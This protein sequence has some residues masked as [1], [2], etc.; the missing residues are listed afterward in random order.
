MKHVH[1]II[2][3][4]PLA[5]SL[6]AAQ[7]SIQEATDTLHTY[8]WAN[9]KELEGNYAQAALWYDKLM[10]SQPPYHVHKGH[11]TFL[12]ATGQVGKI[13][14]LMPSLETLFA[15]DVEVQLIFAQALQ[16]VGKTA[17]AENRFLQLSNKFKHDQSVAFQAASIY[18]RRHELENALAT[19]DNVL[20]GS[21]KKQ[22]NFIFH[23]LKAQIYMQANQ[24]NKAL[25]SIKE[26]LAL[27]PRFDKGI[28]LQALLEE[29][30]GRLTQAM[31]GF[32]TYLEI[33]GSQDATIKQHL[34]Q[35][36][37]KQKIAQEHINSAIMNKT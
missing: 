22:N 27:H 30:A 35:L 28:L 8:L 19:I 21:P 10:A 25:Q 15:D 34:L 14:S 9:Y 5:A 37:F 26:S 4:L 1:Y 17:D 36:A 24:T 3:L 13:L 33:T 16:K 6:S 18:T 7:P 2:A 31:Q 20:N 12:S 32:T 23:F 29:Q 11:I